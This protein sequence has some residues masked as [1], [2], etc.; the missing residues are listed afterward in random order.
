M[1]ISHVA[2]IIARA[3]FGS[4]FVI[5]AIDYYTGSNLKYIIIT[6]IRR[7][8]IPGFNLAFVYP[9]FQGAGMSSSFTLCNTNSIL[10][11]IH[12]VFSDV[13]LI[14]VWS[15]LIAVRFIIQS[16]TFLCC[17]KK[18][19]TGLKR[20]TE[21]ESLLYNYHDDYSTERHIRR[22]HN[23]SRYYKRYIIL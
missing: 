18:F 21:T 4:Y 17:E 2:E 19:T 12:S 5:V 13:T 3:I 22:S 15:V 20:N 16:Y 14:I 9:P 1:T 8:T 10:C 11:S 7:I 6:I 23:Q